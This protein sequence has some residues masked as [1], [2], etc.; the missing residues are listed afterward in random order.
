MI[1][2]GIVVLIAYFLALAT[3]AMGDDPPSHDGGG[4]EREV[5]WLY[6]SPLC[7]EET[8]TVSSPTPLSMVNH[9]RP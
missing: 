9:C 5:Q 8:I 6:D 7:V 4:G 2:A 3:P 1:R